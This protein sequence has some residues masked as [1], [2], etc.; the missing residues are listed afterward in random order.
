MIYRTIGRKRYPIVEKR[1]LDLCDIYVSATQRVIKYSGN[2]ALLGIKL[3]EIKN[4]YGNI[5]IE[6]ANSI[7]VYCSD[8]QYEL[9]WDLITNMR[10]EEDIAG[11]IDLYTPSYNLIGFEI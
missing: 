7:K 10:Y 11:I 3:E 2:Y 1:L 4:H 8:E 6:D 9:Y 5:I